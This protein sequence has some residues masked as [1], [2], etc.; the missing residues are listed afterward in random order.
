M[1]LT[2]MHFGN[3]CM[4]LMEVREEVQFRCM[5]MFEAKRQYYLKIKSKIQVEDLWKSNM[6]NLFN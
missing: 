2:T 3:K 5:P 4:Y 6:D 1:R